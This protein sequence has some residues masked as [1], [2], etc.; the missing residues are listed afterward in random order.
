M[1]LRGHNPMA[2]ALVIADH[3]RPPTLCLGWV[4]PSQTASGKRYGQLL[5]MVDSK[6]QG[7]RGWPKHSHFPLC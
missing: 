5:K 4:W 6:P 3:P 1:L 7:H 2:M